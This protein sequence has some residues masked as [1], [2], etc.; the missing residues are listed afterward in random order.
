MSIHSSR[1]DFC[2]ERLINLKLVC[3]IYKKNWNYVEI[4]LE[5]W[6]NNYN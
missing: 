3:G 5:V 1:F 2:K 4:S 6:C